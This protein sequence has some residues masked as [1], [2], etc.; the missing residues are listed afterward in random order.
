MR[1]PCAKTRIF[2]V[3]SV[4]VMNFAFR[5]DKIGSR[6]FIDRIKNENFGTCEA[7]LRTTCYTNLN[8]N[9]EVRKN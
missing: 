9:F 7:E 1:F 2:C 6:L 4:L 3:F 8:T 5:K